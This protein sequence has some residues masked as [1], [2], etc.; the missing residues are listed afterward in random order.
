MS[1]HQFDAIK[2]AFLVLI[3]FVST[4]YI[5]THSRY[6]T[7]TAGPT[8][9]DQSSPASV[10]I[11]YPKANESVALDT[12]YTYKWSACNVSKPYTLTLT[13]PDGISVILGTSD[14]KNYIATLDSGL[15]QS[16]TYLLSV[17]SS[18]GVVSPIQ[19]FTT[20]TSYTNRYYNEIFSG[21]TL[22]S[23]ISYG[24]ALASDGTTTDLKLDLYQPTGDASK[25]RAA[26]IFVHGGAFT[27]GDKA[28]GSNAELM[29]K[30]FALRGYVTAS[31]NY[32]LQKKNSKGYVKIDDQ[33]KTV[34][35]A[36]AAVRWLR[37][38]AS[39]YGI[40]PNRIAIG[41]SS[42]GAAITTMVAYDNED[43]QG[44]N[45]SNGTISDQVTS[46]E[47]FKGYLIKDKVDGDVVIDAGE[48][49]NVNIIGTLDDFYSEAQIL[50]DD[51]VA[52]GIQTLFYPVD[53][54]TH[55]SIGWSNTLQYSVPFFCKW[56]AGFCTSDAQDATITT[57]V[58]GSGSDG[59]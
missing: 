13:K 50:N 42:A 54:G 28:G 12:N 3:I 30:S 49:E 53:G 57:T 9:C 17:S 34:Y 43:G 21:Y 31:I 29:A 37:A 22:T 48:T 47:I 7:L 45:T 56:N 14:L 33:M 35:D 40:D 25:F 41:G 55:T 23:D 24:S 38:N 36:K 39:T 51:A 5:L 10:T 44:D 11:K 8:L 18:D 26:L 2:T 6:L 20:T 1:N 32:R 46:A 27:G 16:G 59:E 19:S 58:T 4:G 52:V 15:Y